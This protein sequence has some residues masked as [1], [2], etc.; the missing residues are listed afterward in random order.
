V[1][2]KGTKTQTS[3][4]DRLIDNEPGI[5]S[6]PVQNRLANFRQLMAM[7]R[8]D[9]ENLLNTKNFASSMDSG[10]GELQ[11][12]LFFYGLPDFTAQN[13]RDT[14]VRDNLCQEVER[15]IARFEPRLTNVV[16]VSE[17]GHQEERSLGFKIMGLLMV[18]PAPE[19]V[20][21]DTH[22]DVNRGEYK[23]KG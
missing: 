17:T 2:E 12:S 11:K 6:E 5:S 4:L 23:V 14:S 15:A 3:I 18:E 7:V 19:A 13:P 10:Y 21:F 16:V 8:R 9:I 20:T 1:K 22:F